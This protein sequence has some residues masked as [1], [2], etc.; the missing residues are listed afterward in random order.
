MPEFHELADIVPLME[1]EAFERLVEDVRSNGVLDAIVLYEGK[2][3][4]GRNRY[5]ALTEINKG[6]PP[7]ERMS[8]PEIKFEERYP[9]TDP[10]DFVRSEER[11]VRKQGRTRG[12]AEQREQK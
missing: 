3:L 9:H 8:H 1:G 5:R 7:T 2:I 6:Q 10:A 11:R 4:D 12:S